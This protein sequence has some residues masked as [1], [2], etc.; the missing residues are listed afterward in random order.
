M[1]GV[2]PSVPHACRCP[3]DHCGRKRGQPAL[4]RKVNVGAGVEEHGRGLGLTLTRGGG[5]GGGHGWCYWLG[6]AQGDCVWSHRASCCRQRGGSVRRVRR[7]ECGA[8][9]QQLAQLPH[10][11]EARR[12]EQLD[13]FPA[14]ALRP[15]GAHA[16]VKLGVAGG[17]DSAKDA[18]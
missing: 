3:L 5:G 4:L 14:Y 13:V 11:A 12:P 17:R 15:I 8:S 10:A 2:N 9:L 7:V 16:H 18:P 1:S 6:A